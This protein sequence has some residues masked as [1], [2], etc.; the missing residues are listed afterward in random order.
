MGTL[1]FCKSKTI[2]KL[3]FRKI[4]GNANRDVDKPNHS[5]I[6]QFKKTEHEPP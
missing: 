3:S 2:L 1:F 6:G 5:Y 4:T